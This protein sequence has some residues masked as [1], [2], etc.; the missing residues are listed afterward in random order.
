[1]RFVNVTVVRPQNFDAYIARWVILL[2]CNILSRAA[3]E[4][5][6]KFYQ[7]GRVGHRSQ[8][9]FLS[10]TNIAVNLPMGMITATCQGHGSCRPIDT[11]Q[12]PRRGNQFP[13]LVDFSVRASAGPAF[14]PDPGSIRANNITRC[15]L[16]SGS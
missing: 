6:I 10:R 7:R 12:S 5:Y 4:F 9:I 1:M 8:L 2:N 16:S 3:P 13:N 15:D 11:R 14:Y